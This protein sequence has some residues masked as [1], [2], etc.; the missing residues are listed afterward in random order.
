MCVMIP[1]RLELELSINMKLPN[2]IIIT[3]TT[4]VYVAAAQD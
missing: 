3:T 4:A 1:Y 2:I